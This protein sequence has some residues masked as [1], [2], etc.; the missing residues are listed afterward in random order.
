[1]VQAFVFEIFCQLAG[2]VGGAVVTEQPQ[3]PDVLEVTS[4]MRPTRRLSH[5][6]HTFGPELIEFLEAGIGVGLQ[7]AV[8][9]GEVQRVV[10]RLRAGERTRWMSVAFAADAASDCV[11]SQ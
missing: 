10:I 6:R 4:E 2:D 8:E 7:D 5:A 1:M 3:F 9:V 11:A